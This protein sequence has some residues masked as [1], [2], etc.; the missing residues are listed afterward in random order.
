[1][2]H[3]YKK[4]ETY[5]RFPANGARG[6]VVGV[7]S[8]LCGVVGA[9]PQPRAPRGIADLCSKLQSYGLVRSS[10][11]VYLLRK[12]LLS[13]HLALLN[14]QIPHNR[15]GHTVITTFPKHSHAC[16]VKQRNVYCK[17]LR[18]PLPSTHVHVSE[19][20]QA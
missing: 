6:V 7:C 15:R 20:R 13:S 5:R 4:G 2:E 8:L 3:F 10:T 12:V 1:V 14:P 11:H 18:E 9:Q 17:V 16:V 19:R